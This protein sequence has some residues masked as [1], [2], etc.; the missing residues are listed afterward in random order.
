MPSSVPGQRKRD[1]AKIRE[2]AEG[3]SRLSLEN[4]EEAE[5]MNRITTAPVSE[6]KPP[7]FYVDIL[8][9][10]PD[11]TFP[12]QTSNQWCHLMT[13]GTQEDL[14]NF[15][16]VIGLNLRWIQKPG[17]EL[18]H[19]D[20]TESLRS[21]AIRAGA[22]AVSSVTLFRACVLPKRTGKVPGDIAAITSG[23]AELNEG[24]ELRERPRQD[25]PEETE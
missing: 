6:N 20:L 22:V 5:Q 18:V 24:A 25:K 4:P 3:Q 13:T 15:A 14:Q 17:T 7:V 8:R 19:F 10:Y 12:G 16:R 1:A 21:K 2:W 23:V 9:F 11:K